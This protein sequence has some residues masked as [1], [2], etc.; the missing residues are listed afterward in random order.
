SEDAELAHARARSTSPRRHTTESGSDLQRTPSSDH[1]GTPAYM[2]PEQL[3]DGDVDHRADQFSLAVALYEALVRRLP[4]RG[5]T[6]TQ[7]ALSVLQG[8]PPAFP[9]G[10]EVPREIQRAV[11]R[12]MA[13]DPKIRF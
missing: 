4:F 5:R 9:R 12:G 13:R 10:A 8:P 6:P 1:V 7:Y 2:S 3:L 11:L